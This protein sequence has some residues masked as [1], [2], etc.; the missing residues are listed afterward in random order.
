MKAILI[1]AQNK[2]IVLVEVRKDNIEDYHQLLKCDIFTSGK[3]FDNRDV[4]FVD[5]EGLIRGEVTEA[6]TFDGQLFAGNGLIVGGT[7]SGEGADA[8]TTLGALAGRIAFPPAG[9][10]LDGNTQ[11][12]LTKWK[13]IAF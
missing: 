1:D 9:W 5:D 7:P 10:V 4:M 11:D 2:R 6:F 12:Q 3:S 8:K 13:I